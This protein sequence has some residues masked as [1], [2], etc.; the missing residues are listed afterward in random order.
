MYDPAERE[1]P[2]N[3]S[4]ILIPLD[5]P[6]ADV[7]RCASQL[8]D[9]EIRRAARFRQPADRQR[10][11]VAHGTLRVLLARVTGTEPVNVSLARSSTGKPRLKD[12]RHPSSSSFSLSHSGDWAAVAIGGSGRVGVDIERIDPDVPAEAIARRFFSHDEAEAL[13]RLPAAQR[14]AAFFATWTRKEAYIKAR[15]ETIANRLRTFTVSVGPS[16][17]ASLL[18]DDIHPSSPSHWKL[19]DLN[20]A[21]GYSGSLATDGPLQAVRVTWWDHASTWDLGFLESIHSP[22]CEMG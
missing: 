7:R 21:V 4:V 13:H 17:D 16:R 12:L 6:E 3:I 8:S 18:V 20:L 5:V 10:Y 2:A 22:R 11:V 19:A 15:G 1:E 14:L 9:D